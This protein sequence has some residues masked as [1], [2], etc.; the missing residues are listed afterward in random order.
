MGK[1]KGT[2]PRTETKSK[3]KPTGIPEQ[4][5]QLQVEAYL[6]LKGLHYYHFPDEL[7]RLCSPKVIIRLGKY[8]ISW[9]VKNAVRDSGKG[10]P[11]LLI[12]KPDVYKIAD[13]EIKRLGNNTLML[14]LKKLHAKARKVQLNWHRGLHVHVRDTVE[15]AIKLIQQWEDEND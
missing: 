6:Q 2:L 11:D 10:L 8:D 15:L 7:Y 12:F 4:S 9:P 5:I 1:L 3:L 13:K 14:E